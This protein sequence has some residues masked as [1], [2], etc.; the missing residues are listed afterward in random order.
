MSFL[1]VGMNEVNLHTFIGKCPAETLQRLFPNVEKKIITV[2]Q[3]KAVVVFEESSGREETITL[4]FQYL[5]QLEKYE[6]GTAN[7]T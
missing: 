2:E 7:V 1:I 6:A 5:S 4:F 3:M